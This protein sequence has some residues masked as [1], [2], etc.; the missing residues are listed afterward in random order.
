MYL[1]QTNKWFYDKHKFSH[2]LVCF[3]MDGHSA[4]YGSLRSYVS[5]VDYKAFMFP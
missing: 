3:L 4:L 5:T 1:L 2:E